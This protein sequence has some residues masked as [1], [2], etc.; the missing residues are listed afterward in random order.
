MTVTA[1]TTGAGRPVSPAACHS[2]PHDGGHRPQL[3]RRI[4]AGEGPERGVQPFSIRQ[5]DGEFDRR[6]TERIEPFG[7]GALDILLAAPPQ[8]ALTRVMMALVRV[9]D[10]IYRVDGVRIANIYLVLSADGVMV[11]DSGMPG[12][13]KRILALIEQLGRQPADL[14][15]VV[16]THWH[17]D[18][19]GSAAELRNLTG[20]QVAIHELDAPALSGRQRPEKGR[21]VMAALDR[22]FRSR[23]VVPDVRL[24]DGDVI[25]GL[26]VVHV[27]GHTAGS[28]ALRRDDGVVFCGDALLSDRR[29]RVMP[30]NT[31]LSLDPAQVLAS[32]ERV[33]ALPATLLLPGHG[34]PVPV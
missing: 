13:A 16:L 8:L 34:P 31:S 7:F 15:F 19:M 25:G 2:A 30:P 20:A 24:R 6:A 27:P 28:T 22:L 26:Q 17:I 29:G 5:P 11:V 18:H 1:Q 10:G 3:R 33:K 23:P 14:R 12:N 32:A 9:A 4:P 21:L